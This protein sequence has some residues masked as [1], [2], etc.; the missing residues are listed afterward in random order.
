MDII[1]FEWIELSAKLIPYLG[2]SRGF[3][4]FLPFI[5]L[6][7]LPQPLPLHPP[8]WTWLMKLDQET[9]YKKFEFDQGLSWREPPPYDHPP[10]E[11]PLP[12]TFKNRSPTHHN[13]LTL[14]LIQNPRS[15]ILYF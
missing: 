4:I 5:P 15:Y 3:E 6:Q 10:T 2:F 11:R 8:Q 13:F 9:S 12:S 7:P 1:Y 14:P